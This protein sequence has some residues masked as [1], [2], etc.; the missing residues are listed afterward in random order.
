M[1]T[2]YIFEEIGFGFLD[3]RNAGSSLRWTVDAKASFDADSEKYISVNGSISL[4]DCSRAIN[5]E[6]GYSD[7][8]DDKLT[9][10]IDELVRCRSALRKAR[11]AADKWRKETGHTKPIE[12]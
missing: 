12:D 1:S 8:Y 6:L 11:K 5:W 7:H 10:A 9:K 4:T 3:P 2:K